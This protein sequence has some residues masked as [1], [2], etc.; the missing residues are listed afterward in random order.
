MVLRPTKFSAGKQMRA[1]IQNDQ[2]FV[3]SQDIIDILIFTWPLAVGTYR[4]L[5]L[6]IKRHD[7]DLM[8]PAIKK[9]KL[10][11]RAYSAD[12]W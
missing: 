12:R 5:A 2:D 9:D 7:Y 3:F 6:S 11:P 4:S 8:Q 10:S 1:F